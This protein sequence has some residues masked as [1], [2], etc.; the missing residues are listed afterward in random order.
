MRLL[1]PY[2]LYL[3]GRDRDLIVPDT[4]RHKGLWPTLGRPGR[5]A[6]RRRVVG[7]WRPRAKGRT[8]ALELDEWAPWSRRTR[9]AVDVEHAR[10][11]EFR[12]VTPG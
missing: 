9:A 3:Q 2:D 10:L 11:A 7:T 5:G 12:G 4:T 6:G 8:L 1:G